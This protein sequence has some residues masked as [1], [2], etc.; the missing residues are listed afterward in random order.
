MSTDRLFQIITLLMNHGALTAK[1]L[2]RRLE[3][4][5]RTIYRDADALSAAGVPVRTLPGR[6][7]GLS[8]MEGYTLERR[9]FS[10]QEQRQILMGVQSLAAA[11]PASQALAQKLSALFQAPEADWIQVDFSR[12]GAEKEDQAKF[13]ALRAATL[14]RRL[15]T[16]RYAAA[17][18]QASRRVVKPARLVFKAAAWY[19]QAWCLERNAFRTFKI[20]RISALIPLPQHFDPLPPPPPVEAMSGQ[21]TLTRFVMRCAPCLAGRVYDEFDESAIQPQADGSLQVIFN[22]VDEPSLYGYLLSFGRGMRLLSPP[23]AA[24]RLK[25]EAEKIAAAYEKS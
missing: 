18:G 19:L 24:A 6:G 7:G 10:P 9:L 14:E 13:E 8:L 11:Y 21:A 25:A 22:G 4:S 16:F 23:E 2:A 20:H 3:V 17:Y 5:V 15:I 1:E 12:W